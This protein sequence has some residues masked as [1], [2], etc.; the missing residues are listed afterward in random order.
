MAEPPP[1]VL[2]SASPRRRELLGLLGVPF[3][4]I[5]SRY[6]ERMPA[7]HRAPARLATRLAREKAAEVA[8]RCPGRIV[9]GA[10]TIVVLG[11]RVLGKPVDAADARA[12]LAALGGRAHRVITG[13]AVID[14]GSGRTLLGMETTRVEFRQL[15]AAEIEAYVATGEPM[16]KAGAYGIQGVGGLLA[17]GVRGDFNNVVGLPVTTLMLLLRD[18][19]VEILGVRA[20]VGKDANSVE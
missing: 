5:P 4:V 20:V 14:G 17:T 12:M 13:L 7:E 16:D 18:L 3:E 8:R 2:A 10:D 1:L 19:E 6:E 9:I 11:R 15:A